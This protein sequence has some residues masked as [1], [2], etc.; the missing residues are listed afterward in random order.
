M[1][2]APPTLSVLHAKGHHH[3]D[4][5]LANI[6]ALRMQVLLFT[7]MITIVVVCHLNHFTA[8]M[9]AMLLNKLI[10]YICLVGCL[11]QLCHE[12]AMSIDN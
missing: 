11:L 10:V 2:R 8:Q 5:P 7:G 6:I 4:L 1:L 3:N 9:S 12:V